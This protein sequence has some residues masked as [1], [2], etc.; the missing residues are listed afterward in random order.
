VAV[1][2]RDSTSK[3]PARNEPGRDHHGRDPKRRIEKLALE[4]SKNKPEKDGDTV[5]RTYDIINAGPKNRFLASGRIVS[6][7]GRLLQVQ[8]LPQ[9]K[10]PDLGA[11]RA[12]VRAGEFE[13]VEMLYDSIST[14]LSELIRT[15]II[16]EP[17]C[18]LIVADFSA[19]EARVIAWLAKEQW[20][21]D[22]FATHGKIYEASAS[23][24]FHV[25]LE[26]I[27]RDHPLR[28]KGKVAELALGYG[29]SSKALEAM[30][31][32][33]MGLAEE[34]LPDIVRRWR[35]ANRHIVSW[36]YS[37]EN[38]AFKALSDASGLDEIGGIRFRFTNNHLFM[39]L[40][41]GRSL[42]YYNARIGRNRFGSPSIHYEGM[43]QVTRRWEVADTYGG[44]L[45]ENCVAKGTQVV[46]KRG[47]V[48]IQNVR[49][50]DLLWDGSEWVC[51]EGLIEKGKQLTLEV[52]GVSL[53]AD[54][55]VLTD[56]GW[57]SA[58]SCSGS[59]RTE[60]E[61]P[62]RS[63]IRG[64]RWEEI[65]MEYSLRLWKSVSNACLRVQKRGTE[66]LR[67]QTRGANKQSV[68][69]AWHVEAP[70]VFSVAVDDRPMW[71]EITSVLAQL[72][73]SWD[74]CL[75]KLG[76][77]FRELLEGHGAHLPTRANLREN[78]YRRWVLPGELPMGYLPRT[79]EKS[80]NQS[81][82]KHPLG[83]DNCFRSLRDIRYPPKHSPLSSASRVPGKLTVHQTRRYEP[84]Y[85]LKN[86]GPKHRFTVMG[87]DGPMILH[88]CT[89]AT[90]R[91]CLRDAMLR[92]DEAEYDIRMHVHDE[93]IINE[94]LT[95]RS[96]K[97]VCE[98]MGRP[99]DW[100]PGLI[101]R[102]DGFETEYYR[103]D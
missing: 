68:K 74:T 22:V 97:D 66:I 35:K 54:H 98:I 76:Q 23:A 31:A 51:H 78:R 45:A 24:M 12:L 103:K 72:R 40:P 70:G 15:A 91:D 49:T 82:G 7:S 83:E 16:P 55:L 94:P 4:R 25:P 80:E 27:T 46:T 101:L 79:G 96:Y 60:V 81:V 28:Q 53:T 71:A 42:C 86:S 30:G 47:V 52:N 87:A 67:M 61:L 34:E 11:A 26:E 58:S 41:S 85:D 102:A 21:L 44:K 39:D 75:R 99:I 8:N 57:R 73:R 62:H 5:T 100:A 69:H 95:G 1:C 2:E 50:S 84:V 64:F 88:N 13:T 33:N 29:G 89:Q 43:N 6:N 32:L 92:L 19:I 18:K 9:N 90:A 36:W 14:T 56:R 63:F 65:H 93:V 37:L 59:Y 20:R 38:A 17:S 77:E 3:D 10:L 48:E